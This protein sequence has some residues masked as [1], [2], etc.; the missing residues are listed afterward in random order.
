MIKTTTTTKTTKTAKTK[1]AKTAKSKS[2]E[3]NITRIPISQ[4]SNNSMLDRP[5]KQT[6]QMLNGLK[7]K[8]LEPIFYPNLYLS[9]QGAYKENGAVVTLYSYRKKIMEYNRDT[10]EM[11]R[12]Y[13]GKDETDRH[14]MQLDEDKKT[15]KK[16]GWSYITSM[17]I[18]EFSLQFIGKKLNKKAFMALPYREETTEEETKTKI[19][20]MNTKTIKNSEYKPLEYVASEID[21]TSQ[22]SFM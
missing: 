19:T 1:M 14:N 3:L 7:L 10:G 6:V 13:G 2:Y 17:H 20:T 11:V 21:T 5:R 9:C 22:V 18:A 8:K 12:Y 4:G 15:I 16:Q